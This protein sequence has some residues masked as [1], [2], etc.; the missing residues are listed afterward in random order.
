MSEVPYHGSDDSDSSTETTGVTAT[1]TSSEYRILGKKSAT[2]G[3]GILG[4]NTASS[5]MS[6]GVEGQTDA[7]G[8]ASNDIHPPGVLGRATGAGTTF[9]V[10]GRGTSQSTAG[11]VGDASKDG[12]FG[13]GRTGVPAGVAGGTDR[14][15]ADTGVE[16][17]YGVIGSAFSTSGEAYGVAG[18][19]STPDGAGVQGLDIDG[20]GLGVLSNGDSKTDGTHE[21]T[22]GTIH[23][24]RGDPSTSEL[25]DGAVMT[26]NSDGS[27]T[28]NAGD[29]VYAVNDGGTIKT[30][31]IAQRSN[32]T[33]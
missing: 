5:G 4:R 10:Y 15:S 16:F 20:N 3:T 2:D 13:P 33:A 27:G 17:G 31:V 8:D 19:S 23:R 1:A 21:V 7:D 18:Q 12:A 22:D 6:V 25:P 30:Q 24:Q 28:G 26:Y 29:L 9:G 32:A 11:V 14:S